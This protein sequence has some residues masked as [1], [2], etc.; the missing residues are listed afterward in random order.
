[1]AALYLDE[2]VATELRA[3]LDQ[4]GHVVTTTVEARRA[5]VPDPHQLLHA[6]AQNSILV[7]HNRRDFR[8]LH[9]AWLVWGGAWGARNPHAGIVIIEQLRRPA[10]D[11]FAALLDAFIGEQGR[12]IANTLYDWKPSRGWTTYRQ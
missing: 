11:D 4:R 7:T 10:L 12:E 6:A 8:L 9:T 1:M 5:G 2:N 3:L